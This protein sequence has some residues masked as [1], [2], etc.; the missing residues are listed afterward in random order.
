MDNNPLPAIK[1]KEAEEV[2]NLVNKQSNFL[3]ACPQ[4][5]NGL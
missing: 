5:R 2:S 4:T 3:Q 1:D